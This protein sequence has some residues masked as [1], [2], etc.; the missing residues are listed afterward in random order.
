MKIPLTYHKSMKNVIT[1]ELHIIMDRNRTHNFL[2]NRLVG[3]FMVFNA[4]FNNHSVIS[5]WSFLLMEEI[6][7]PRENHRP[8]VSH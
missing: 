3:W 7:A 5:W 4:T 2:S 8:A 6:G 1:L